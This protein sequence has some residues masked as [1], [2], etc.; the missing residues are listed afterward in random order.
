MHVLYAGLLI[1]LGL[2]TE[3]DIRK[4]EISVK[5]AICFCLLAVIIRVCMMNNTS[6]ISLL[7][8]LACALIPGIGM[9]IFSGITDQAV[10]YEDGIIMMVCGIYLGEKTA[11]ALLLAG[12]FLMFPVSMLLLLSGKA[13]RET[14]L[15]F[16]PF[17]LNA[18]LLWLIQR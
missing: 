9:L 2:E 15:P 4:R 16:A 1:Y 17:L 6:W 10:G 8:D 7:K 14:E 18:Y 13:K 5:I 11:A 3:N 12:L